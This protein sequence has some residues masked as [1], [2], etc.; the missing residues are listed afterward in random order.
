MI[1]DSTH[2]RASA[3]VCRANLPRK[4]APPLCCALS[5]PSLLFALIT[6]CNVWPRTLCSGA[7]CSGECLGRADAELAGCGQV[8]ADEQLLPREV[9]ACPVPGEGRGAQG[10]QSCCSNTAGA[11]PDTAVQIRSM[12]WGLVPSFTKKDGKADFWRMF[13]CRS[14]SMAVK[15][16]FRR[17]IDRRRCVV[18]MDGFYEW[19]NRTVKG[20]SKPVKQPYFIHLNGVPY[21]LMAGLFD[22]WE[23][24]EGEAVFSY[25]ILTTRSSSALKWLHHRMPVR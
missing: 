23:N 9:H 19:H 25:T 12:R 17:L 7:R 14:E 5:L 18:F 21:M 6:R 16:A 8:Q 3:G 2:L 22:V 1:E 13:N 20:L 15:P 24:S 11:C 10:T 4:R